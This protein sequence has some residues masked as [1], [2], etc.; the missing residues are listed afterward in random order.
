M[1][2]LYKEKDH[3]KMCIFNIHILNKYITLQN[4]VSGSH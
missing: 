1:K 4:S 2:Y 3:F